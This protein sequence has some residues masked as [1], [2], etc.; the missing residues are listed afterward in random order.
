MHA[1]PLPG[2]CAFPRQGDDERRALV[3]WG[4][5][6]LN[7]ELPVFEDVVIPKTELYLRKKLEDRIDTAIEVTPTPHHP[8][9]PSLVALV[10][11]FFSF[12]L[13][14]LPLL[15]PRKINTTTASR[16]A[17]IFIRFTSGGATWWW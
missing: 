15:S 3:D 1:S 13:F 14:A 16:A 9:S 5:E 7:T 17:P 8:S 4:D 10:L 2:P 12:L 11:V 6:T